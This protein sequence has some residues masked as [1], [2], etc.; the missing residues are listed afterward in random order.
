VRAYAGYDALGAD[1]AQNRRVFELARSFDMDFIVVEP[2]D[3]ALWDD[4]EK[5]VREF[6]IPVAIHNH[7][8]GTVYAD[9]ATRRKVLAERD[10]RIG[11][12]LDVGW[13]VAAGH[14]M[15]KVF[16][17]YGDRVWDV[18]LKDET[19]SKLA[20]GRPYAEDLPTGQGRAN[21]KDLAEQMKQMGWSGVLALES[22][23]KEVAAAPAEFIE[24]GRK[25]FPST[26]T[27]VSSQSS[28]P[29]L[30]FSVLIRSGDAAG[31]AASDFVLT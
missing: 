1:M 18:H 17:D 23:S 6:G 3:L 14:D 27:R 5:L 20:D 16:L 21:L 29:S 11:V 4:I 28:A 30:A 19:E 24:N 22:D 15:A 9:P 31:D 7:G 25:F 8:P 13:A 2:K 26:R 12:C 10:A